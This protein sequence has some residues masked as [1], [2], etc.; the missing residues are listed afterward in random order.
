VKRLIPKKD[1]ITEKL[2]SSEIKDIAIHIS[3]ELLHDLIEDYHHALELDTKGIIKSDISFLDFLFKFS[4]TD[5]RDA[6]NI[7]NNLDLLEITSYALFLIYLRSEPR[8]IIINEK[9]RNRE[10][11]YAISF[12]FV[13]VFDKEY[14]SNEIK[15]LSSDELERYRT[16]LF[17][18]IKILVDEYINGLNKLTDTKK[19][20]SK[21]EELI[22]K[23]YDINKL[24]KLRYETILGKLDDNLDNLHSLYVYYFA[25]TYLYDLLTINLK[26]NSH[27]LDLNKSY[28]RRGVA[29][30]LAI[31]Y[32]NSGVK[33]SILRSS[34]NY[35]TSLGNYLNE[36]LSK[37]RINQLCEEVTDAVMVIAG[38]K[39]SL[40]LYK[41]SENAKK[42]SE[43]ASFLFKK[44]F[45]YFEEVGKK[46]N[47][48]YLLKILEIA[49][50]ERTK[51][52]IELVIFNRENMLNPNFSIVRD[53]EL[54][55]EKVVIIDND[56]KNMIIDFHKIVQ[57]NMNSYDIVIWK[58]GE[59]EIE[60]P[61]WIIAKLN[62]EKIVL[63][64][65]SSVIQETFGNVSFSKTES[66]NPRGLNNPLIIAINEK[67]DD[68]N[69]IHKLKERL[70]EEFFIP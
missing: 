21:I 15:E 24:A 55:G 58:N 32:S 37:E 59:I 25:Y 34:G 65:L 66:L 10:Q 9:R 18:D 57:E 27:H 60:I 49:Y 29:R 69:K 35:Y 54:W 42:F 45:N 26:N 67:I 51:N 17:G 39:D 41:L 31:Y 14:Y 22:S 6:S 62:G 63:S 61:Y 52:R 50:L 53:L 28:I 33:E 68:Y 2:S 40:E 11:F 13:D 56:R 70:E 4:M 36:V 8:S 20:N 1:K 23:W 3:V 7:H 16:K 64:K 30:F 46:L 38:A 19:I 5:R 43:K 44:Y 48:D 12:R 47:E